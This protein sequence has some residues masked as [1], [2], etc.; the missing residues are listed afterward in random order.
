MELKQCDKKCWILLIGVALIVIGAAL[1]Y[2]TTTYQPQKLTYADINI[3]CEDVNLSDEAATADRE[4]KLQ[5]IYDSP[6]FTEKELEAM[7]PAGCHRVEKSQPEPGS[8]LV[9]EERYCNELLAIDY[10]GIN[11]LGINLPENTPI[12]A[13]ADGAYFDNYTGEKIVEEGE[14]FILPPT[15]V[16][17]WL[18]GTPTS[19]SYLY[20]DGLFA[21]PSR[22]D[23]KSISKGDILIYT[24]STI[25]YLDEVTQSNFVIIYSD[26]EMYAM[27]IESGS[28]GE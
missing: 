4:V 28:P 10:Q 14:E 25:R 15:R 7:F 27:L 6:G 3:L 26:P 17:F 16:E 19:T 9:L 24:A 11:A 22:G 8:C 13:P 2:L 12:F 23:G 21:E 20:F 5:L 18:P 1:Y